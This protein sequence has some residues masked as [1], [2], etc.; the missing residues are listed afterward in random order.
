MRLDNGTFT[1]TNV[2]LVVASG[3]QVNFVNTS[4]PT[5]VF[6]TSQAFNVEASGSKFTDLMP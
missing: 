3:Y 2:T 6:A 5:D 4:D 1:V